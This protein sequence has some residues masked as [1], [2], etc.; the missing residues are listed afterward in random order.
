MQ[1]AD[2]IPNLPADIVRHAL[3]TLIGL[4]PRP[5]ADTPENRAACEATAVAAVA[6][7]RPTDAFQLLLAVQIVGTYA[8][9]ME[10]LRLSAEPGRSVDLVA[11]TRSWAA[12]LI[13]VMHESLRDLGRAQ[14]K[15]QARDHPYRG[16]IPGGAEARTVGHRSCQAEAPSG[17]LSELPTTP[18]GVAD[19]FS[20]SPEPAFANGGA[21]RLAFPEELL[22]ASSDRGIRALRQGLARGNAMLRCSAEAMTSRARMR[23][24]RDARKASPAVQLAG[25]DQRVRR[26]A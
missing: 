24:S 14:A 12:S 26:M 4:L 8:H 6:A 15:A 10:C 11:R 17:E 18:P 16:T 25:Q 1:I 7:L 23:S 20:S 3:G 9:A 2:A 5:T 13:R 21:H 22:V 19:R